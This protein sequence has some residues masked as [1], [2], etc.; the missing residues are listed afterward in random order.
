MHKD[1]VQF[2]YE[3]LIKYDAD[4]AICKFLYYT[5]REDISLKS[6]DIETLG[7][8]EENMRLINRNLNYIVVWNKLYKATLFNNLRFIPNKVHEDEF[9]IH[10]IFWKA[11]KSVISENILYY[12]R[13]ATNSITNS[14]FNDSKLQNIIEAFDD[15]IS[16]YK[17]NKIDDL[18]I[19]FNKKWNIIIHKGVKSRSNYARKYI[20]NHIIE[21][22]TK[23]QFPVKKKIKLYFKLLFNR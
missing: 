9:I 22:F 10:H 12:Y 18:K 16:F 23:F 3:A 7:N 6:K 20:L 13:Q 4:I 2:L 15:R 19:V 5:G 11:E 14:P 17:K 8:R 1:Y 21:F